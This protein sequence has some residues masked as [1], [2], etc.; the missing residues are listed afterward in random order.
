RSV[1]VVLPESMWAEM[2]ILRTLRRFSMFEIHSGA[3]EQRVERPLTGPRT[4]VIK[5][6]RVQLNPP[7][8]RGPKGMPG[9]SYGGTPKPI[10]KRLIHFGVR[11]EKSPRRPC[12][13]EQD[14]LTTHRLTSSPDRVVMGI[15]RPS[16]DFGWGIPGDSLF[17]KAG[18]LNPTSRRLGSLTI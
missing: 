17:F 9:E 10:C 3:V 14:I 12:E 13:C 11:H 6:S 18:P 4:Q 7:F 8:Q 15:I 16:G 2:P 1:S 5:F